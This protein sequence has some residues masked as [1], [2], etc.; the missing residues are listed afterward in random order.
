MESHPAHNDGRLISR[1]EHILLTVMKDF[2]TFIQVGIASCSQLWKGSALTYDL[3]GTKS[4]TLVRRA[5]T[6]IWPIRN[7]IL[8]PCQNGPS[9]RLSYLVMDQVPPFSPRRM[10][11]SLISDLVG[12]KSYTFSKKAYTHIWHGRNWILSPWQNGP[13]SQ[14]K[15]PG[16]WPGASILLE[17]GSCPYIRPGRQNGQHS[18]MTWEEPNPLAM[19]EWFIPYIWSSGNTSLY[20]IRMASQS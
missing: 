6:H 15:L 1:R 3:V 9:P 5:C 10:V 14:T 4:Y 20:H 7:W 12:N 18:H 17:N 2:H 16:N 8:H 13:K 19:I 11:V